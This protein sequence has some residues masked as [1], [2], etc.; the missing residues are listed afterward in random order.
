MLLG[1]AG[2]RAAWLRYRASARPWALRRDRGRFLPPRCQPRRRW[3]AR[4]NPATWSEELL[5]RL[6]RKV[7]L[8]PDVRGTPAEACGRIDALIVAGLP[9]G[10]EDVP[11]LPLL[12]G[13]AGGRISDLNGNDVLSGNGTVLAS[14]GYIHDALLDL[15]RDVPSGRDYQS[16]I[17][18]R[19]Q[20]APPLPYHWAPSSPSTPSQVHDVPPLAV[21]P[22]QR[23]SVPEATECKAEQWQSLST[24]RQRPSGCHLGQPAPVAEAPQVPAG[25]S[26]R[27][28]HI[29][30]QPS[31][32]SA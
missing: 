16:L 10:Y 30:H 7:L 24:F 22:L 8:L 9:M 11:P 1:R 2:A 25:R 19:R 20:P 18:A 15:V 23:G 5:V 28:G 14:N 29:S 3:P 31:G 21:E 12:I 13:E 26:P 4:P 32:L 6:H 17:Q 27:L